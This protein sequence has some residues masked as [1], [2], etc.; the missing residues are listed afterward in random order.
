MSIKWILKM[1]EAGIRLSPED[2][3]LLAQHR[4][5]LA[6]QERINN[7]YNNSNVDTP[8]REKSLTESAVNVAGNFAIGYLIGRNL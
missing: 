2:Y 8:S 3:K 7:S 1:E 4:A 5:K 6:E